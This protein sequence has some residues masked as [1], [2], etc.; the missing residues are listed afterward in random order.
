M[1][2]GRTPAFRDQEP[3]VEDLSAELMALLVAVSNSNGPIGTREA[4]RVL[5]DGGVD[6]SESTV[7]RRLRDL[8]ELG[9]T[10]RA[11]SKGRLVTPSGRDALTASEQ[12]SRHEEL[13][14]RGTRVQTAEDVL[15]LLNAR[16]AIESEAAR[17]AATR[18][19]EVELKHLRD[20][21]SRHRQEVSDGA[22]RVPRALALDF[23]RGVAAMCRNP[24][25]QSTLEVVL[26]ETVDRLEA[27]LDVVLEAHHAGERSVDEHA[28]LLDA[29][30]DGD[31]ALAE[32]AMRD[33]L[34]RLVTEVEE[35]V[36]D[37]HGSMLARLLTWKS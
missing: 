37:G 29:I 2:V 13:L 3:T 21:V 14:R 28:R 22:D 20:L 36:A 15:N 7:S 23:H 18:A 24:L 6:L 26:G 17:E 10:V 5:L 25:L 4:R 33:H 34:G 30:A 32:A 11:G 9:L 35:F 16:R 12:S 1:S 19:G 27:A 8:D 31:A